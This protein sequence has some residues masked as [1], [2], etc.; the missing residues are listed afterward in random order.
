MKDLSERLAD[1]DV[2]LASISVDPEHD[3]P[4][5]LSEYAQRFGAPADRWWFLTG[6]KHEIHDLIQNRFKLGVQEASA[7]RAAAG[8]KRSPTATG[9]PW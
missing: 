2:L 5:V 8:S 3:T 6:D 7:G 4:A 1:S 9:S